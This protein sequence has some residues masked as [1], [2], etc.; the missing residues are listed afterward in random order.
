MRFC[1]M[2]V[3]KNSAACEKHRTAL[4]ACGPLGFF[5]SQHTLAFIP[6]PA[7]PPPSPPLSGPGPPLYGRAPLAHRLVLGRHGRGAARGVRL[8]RRGHQLEDLPARVGRAR[9]IVFPLFHG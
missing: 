2:F 5:P 6:L 9:A 3:C 4:F 1:F 8:G 7:P